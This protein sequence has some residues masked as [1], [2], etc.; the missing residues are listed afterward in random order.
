MDVVKAVPAGIDSFREIVTNEYYYVDKTMMIKELIYPA[1]AKATLQ[2]QDV[3]E[4][5]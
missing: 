5:H 4:N 2:G 1:P 3:L